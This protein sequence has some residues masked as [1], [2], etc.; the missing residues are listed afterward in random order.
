MKYGDIEGRERDSEF[1]PSIREHLELPKDG[2]LER[3]LRANSVSAEQ[4]IDA[5]LK[6][7]APYG[8]MLR[9]VLELFERA[10]ASS[11]DSNLS[12]KF[13]FDSRLEPLAIDLFAFRKLHAVWQSVTQD[14]EEIA[15]NHDT[16][17][18][19]DTLLERF[20]GTFGEVS[21][22]A[23]VRRWLV[24]Y[25]KGRR[26]PDWEPE[27]I[28]FAVRRLDT[29]GR[30]L[31]LL[32]S[33]IVS[34]SRM[35][36][37]SRAALSAARFDGAVFD[38]LEDGARDRVTNPLS[39]AWLL[40]NLDLVGWSGNFI[41]RLSILTQIS[42]LPAGI[43][44]D[45]ASFVDNLPRRELRVA[46]KVR[47]LVDILNLPIWRRR[48]E[49][50]SA[51]VASRIVAGLGA[52]TVV[53]SSGGKLLFSFS[54]YHLATNHY[55][56]RKPIHI[57]GELRTQLSAPKGKGRKKAIQ[58]DFSLTLE[59]I[60]SPE[61]SVLV[62]EVKHYL[63]PARRSFAEALEDYAKGR[64]SAQVVLV[65]YGH[66]GGGVTEKLDEAVQSRCQCIQEFRPGNAEAAEQFA[67]LVRNVVDKSRSEFDPKLS[68]LTVAGPNSKVSDSTGHGGPI[69]EERRN[70]IG[71]IRLHW[72]SDPADLDLH[73][74]LVHK[75]GTLSHVSYEEKEA[76][77]G[78]LAVKLRGDCTT[79]PGEEVVQF[80][81]V[82]E[83]IRCA[84]HN[85]S[86]RPFIS[87]AGAKVV[88][89]IG[90]LQTEYVAPEIGEGPWWLVFDY[91]PLSSELMVWNSFH[92]SIPTPTIE[93]A[94]TQKKEA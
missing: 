45:L 4:M 20:E 92:S 90:G 65:D 18:G 57:W 35:I 11:G 24:E 85:Y 2:P 38:N 37:T 1:L 27:A 36:G 89:K 83:Y 58:P 75:S 5:V 7:A 88:S 69:A 43:E 31:W 42:A 9:D 86:G 50:Y 56:G 22:A 84:V 67:G 76:I 77:D 72:R 17:R 93:A 13:N 25:E 79:A 48:N 60:T 63:Q 49:L 8:E 46:R 61:S 16:I 62:V 39:D 53:H 52:D 23:D 64:R 73:V 59:P 70:T 54:G 47:M 6:V 40:R 71:T 78:S 87:A 94:V 10:I 32:W 81:F 55:L 12:V 80:E 74:W 68:V 14:R 91:W 15:W 51:W 28:P 34:A 26:W 29:Y 33:E 30:E 82:P 21:P 44:Q 66:I 3:Q 41:R 19:V